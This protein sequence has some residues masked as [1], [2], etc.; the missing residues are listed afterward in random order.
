MK[1][2]WQ[3]EHNSICLAAWKRETAEKTVVV[4]DKIAAPGECS[5][6]IDERHALGVEETKCVVRTEHAGLETAQS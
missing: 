6:V 5:V 4:V 3:I 1:H 2:G